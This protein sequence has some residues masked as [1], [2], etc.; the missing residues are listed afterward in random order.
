MC[1]ASLSVEGGKSWNLHNKPGKR[2]VKREEEYERAKR[3]CGEMG[4]FV[5]AEVGVQDG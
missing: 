3:C 1:V 5:R 4:A 2:G